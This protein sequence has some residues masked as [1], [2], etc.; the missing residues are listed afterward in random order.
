MTNTLDKF[1][2]SPE[3]DSLMKHLN[4]LDYRQRR[5][6]LWHRIKPRLPRFLYKFRTLVPSDAT[7]VDRM[8]D[9][10]VRSRFWLSSPLDFND[11]FD[12]SAKLIAEG[13]VIEKRRRLG[14]LLKRQG[15]TWNERSKLLP[16]LVSKSNVELAQLAQKTQRLY[17]ERFGV[18]SFGG[19][20][21]SILMWSHYASNHNGFC[22]QFEVAK[23]LITFTRLVVVQYTDDYPIVNWMKEAEFLEGLGV[24]L[25]RKHTGW[26]YERETRI[27]I[28]N[29]AHEHLSFH[30]EAL[31]GIIT[32]CRVPDV[33]IGCLRELIA[34]R[35]SARL[36]VPVLYRAIQHESKYRLVIRKEL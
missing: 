1:P 24:T 16:N 17:A 25:E 34:E 6:F 14:E 8:R 5:Q 30:P 12:T 20:P 28:P 15:H 22:L 4:E 21:H 10:L 23:D 9:I 13:T 32:G 11:P 2:K 26:K 31:R 3:L 27:I 18:Y 19:D 7:S 29:A 36:P 33:T 35:S